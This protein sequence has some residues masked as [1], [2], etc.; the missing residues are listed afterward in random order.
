MGF[1]EEQVKSLAPKPAAFNAGKK[2]SAAA[3]WDEFAKS[4]RAI[5]GAIRGSG[6]KPY[7]TRIDMQS[8]AYKCTCPSRQ[9]PCKHAIGLMLLYGREEATFEAKE[10]PEW[11]A[12]WL[13]KRHVRQEKQAKEPEK[14]QTDEEKERSEKSKARTQAKRLEEVI[15]GAK[16]LELWLKDLVRTGLL[17]LPE[18]KPSAFEKVAARMVD[19][20]APGLAG[21]VR[22]LARLNYQQQNQWQDEALQITSK[23]YLLIQAIKNHDNLS[24]AWQQ[25]IKNLSGWSQSSKALLADENAETIKD[26][27]LVIGQ[28]EETNDDI[29]VQRNWLIGCQSGRQ[30]LI[31]NF[32]TRFSTFE[33]NV[34]PGALIE[35]ELAFFPSVLP[36]RAAIKQSRE[37]SSTLTHSPPCFE[38]WHEAATARQE[39]ARTNPWY[40]EQPMAL[41]SARLANLEGRWVVIDQ[42]ERWM[43]VNNSFTLD[44]CLRWLSITGNAPMHFTGVVRNGSVLPLGLID[45]QNYTLL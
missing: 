24:P 45:E 31:L 14:E 9:F 44:H 20:K 12:E 1:S 35:G 10:E 28:Q 4:D 8:L 27:W 2:L 19:A 37:V 3:K 16:E 40:A 32:A 34:L 5:W 30:A 15:E 43:P 29:T 6:S 23:L 17:G 21:W 11:V 18:I 25:T 13:D 33:T 39:M 36:Y 41:Q 38:G 42:H 7:L 22:S 26:H